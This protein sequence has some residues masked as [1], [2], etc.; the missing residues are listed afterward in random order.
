MFAYSPEEGTK[1]FTLG[2]PIEKNEKERRKDRLMYIQSEISYLINGKFLNRSLDVLV[3]GH[4]EQDNSV[5][6]GRTQ[7]QAPEVDGVVFID[8][9]E[10]DVDKINSIQKVEINSRDIYDL[11]G[12]FKT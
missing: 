1:S 5:L 4:L 10:Q 12:A 8:S 11:Y 7:F 3:E 9:Q 6:L 2:D